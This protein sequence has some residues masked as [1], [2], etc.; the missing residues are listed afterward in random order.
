MN[1]NHH[2]KRRFRFELFWLK[3][4]GFEEAV[5]EGW[6]CAEHLTDPYVR[7]DDLE[8]WPGTC[9]PGAIARWGISSNK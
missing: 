6:H 4:D 9:R 1:A 7:L 3:L 5:K 2:P 8:T